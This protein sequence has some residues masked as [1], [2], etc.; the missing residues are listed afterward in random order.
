MTIIE[1]DLDKDDEDDKDLLVGQCSSVAQCKQK[2]R[3]R[4]SAE[5]LHLPVRQWIGQK[6]RIRPLTQ[7]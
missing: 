1:G 3:V 4:S 5:L 7:I 6:G 2:P